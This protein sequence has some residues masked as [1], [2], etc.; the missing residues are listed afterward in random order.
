MAPS[1]HS[2]D[3]RSSPSLWLW[4]P[5]TVV[6]TSVVILSLQSVTWPQFLPSTHSCN[7]SKGFS[8]GERGRHEEAVKHFE[9]CHNEEG[10]YALAMSL[11][12]LGRYSEAD[13]IFS[14]LL[15]QNSDNPKYW[16]GYGLMLLSRFESIAGTQHRSNPEDVTTNSF[17]DRGLDALE[18][19]LELMYGNIT[20]AI[21]SSATRTRMR[22]ERALLMKVVPK[23]ISMYV[24]RRRHAAA[25]RLNDFLLAAD[26]GNVALLTSGSQL[27]NSVGNVVAALKKL[28]LS[29]V[30]SKQRATIREL[31][32]EG[33]LPLE[34]AERVEM[35]RTIWNESWTSVH[36]EAVLQLTSSRE[37]K[38]AS[39][40]QELFELGNSEDN[41]TE[42]AQE[43]IKH[44]GVDPTPQ[45]GK[46]A[47]FRKD[48]QALANACHNKQNSIDVAIESGGRIDL[49]TKFGWNALLH[50][51]G[52]GDEDAVKK[53]LRK[54]ADI[55][56]T[57]TYG[58]SAL[59][60][61]AMRGFGH[62]VPL[63]LESGAEEDAVDMF[64]R[65]AVDIACLQNW[66]GNEFLSAYNSYR[67]KHDKP[68]S[69]CKDD[70]VLQIAVQGASFSS[71]VGDSGGWICDPTSERYKEMYTDKCNIIVVDGSNFTTEQF[72][73]HFLTVERPV[74]IRAALKHWLN[75]KTNFTR[76]N[77]YAKYKDL[78]FRKQTI[79]YADAF[80]II[81][82]DT[83]VGEYLDYMRGNGLTDAHPDYIFETLPNDHILLDHHQYPDSYFNE[84]IS[85]ITSRKVQF[86]V[87]P[88]L[89]GAPIH[90]HR[91]AWNGL[92]YGK[93]RWF[94]YPPSQNFYSRKNIH[95]WF[96]QDYPSLSQDNYP[97]ECIQNQDDIAYVPDFWAHGVIN[98]CESIGF[99]SE[100]EWGALARFQ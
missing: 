6:I 61:A 27:S 77:F 97:L 48:L 66:P 64:G 100:L 74:V 3:V 94:L 10:R 47:A 31:E 75:P 57:T 59:H 55:T 34:V 41:A 5:I 85:N 15:K 58:F 69:I 54:G 32:Q 80:G 13:T 65:T 72:V 18:R 63:L 68:E 79:P 20:E 89:S 17:A 39:L 29:Q 70:P 7:L 26:P 16:R 93:K 60:I 36:R 71:Q 50:S 22:K 44:C 62:L 38:L 28:Q 35:E 9:G 37:G 67:L 1:S 84:S 96:Q 4:I 56:A 45:I 23:M 43:Y 81:S 46:Q 91:S 78:S 82:E 83:T 88:V 87:G 86:F 52:Y 24:R 33:K 92:F 53:L 99:A 73:E 25:I 90:F 30:Y 11:G 42:F 12:H 76:E 51:V 21:Q 2:S 40:A 14:E 95:Q 98:L 49:K 8:A 19:Q